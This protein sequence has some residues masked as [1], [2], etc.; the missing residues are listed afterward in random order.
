MSARIPPGFAEVAFKATVGNLD[1]MYCFFGVKLA[2]GITPTQNDTDFILAPATD[3]LKNLVSSGYVCGGGWVT[4]GSDGG[5]IRIDGSVAPVAGG[6]AP[7]AAPPN[8]ATLVQKLTALGGRRN[9][10]RMY[11]PGA[12]ET[13]IDNEGLYGT[14][15]LG[16]LQTAAT[17]FRTQ[18]LA[19]AQVDQLVLLHEQAP[20]TPT[21]IT[22]LVVS[23]TVATQR[24]R[25]RR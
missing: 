8:V 13:D 14:T 21:E 24:R 3:N 2:A 9:R 5:D 23:R 1:P 18:T 22:S 11:L 19:L 15:P 20:F 6:R 12:V 10:G 25:Q 4:W 16:V 7:G 17:A